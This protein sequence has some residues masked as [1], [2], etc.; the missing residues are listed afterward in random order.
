MVLAGPIKAGNWHLIGDGIVGTAADVQFDVIWRRGSTDQTIVS[1]THHFD[2]PP[3]AMKFDAVP[4]EGDAL[5]G[6]VPAL[7]GDLLVLRW[8]IPGPDAGAG[9]IGFIPNGDGAG[10]KGRIPSLTLPH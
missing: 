8:S 7:K 3:E 2:P 6:E 5:G 1:W 10:S 9:G 4:F